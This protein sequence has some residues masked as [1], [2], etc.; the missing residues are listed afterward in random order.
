MSAK[1]KQIADVLEQ[2][3]RDGLFNETEKTTY[4]RSVDES[5]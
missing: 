5:I 3:I 2:N 4:R 1:Y